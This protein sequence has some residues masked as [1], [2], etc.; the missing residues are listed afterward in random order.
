MVA[1]LQQREECRGRIWLDIQDQQ[2]N[3]QEE[4]VK[5]SFLR[6]IDLILIRQ[7]EGL[8]YCLASLRLN[9]DKNPQSMQLD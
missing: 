2:Q 1:G 5:S 4:K 7:Q 6:V 3:Y 9:I 8:Q